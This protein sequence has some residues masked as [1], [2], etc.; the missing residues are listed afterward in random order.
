MGEAGNPRACR[1]TA[2]H[3]SPILPAPSS[4]W[5][6]TS[7]ALNAHGRTRASAVD[8]EA[9][10]TSAPSP[11]G[12]PPEDAAPPQPLRP[13][14]SDEW[15]PAAPAFS[16][17][18]ARDDYASAGGC[19]PSG[20]AWDVRRL[21]SADPRDGAPAGPPAILALHSRAY[22][23]A[24]AVAA[25]RRWA[26]AYTGW[27]LPAAPAGSAG[28]A[29]YQPTLPPPPRVEYDYSGATD[30]QQLTEEADITVDPTPA[31]VAGEEVADEE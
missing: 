16:G 1:R 17:E 13:A 22:P 26:W 7:L 23:G 28:A 6:H 2:A 15:P 8:P 20:G 4:N 11:G 27:G 31:Q 25:G 30:G 29:P 24:V 12:E 19:A 9:P 3:F 21:P 5:V 18:G 10:A 14:S